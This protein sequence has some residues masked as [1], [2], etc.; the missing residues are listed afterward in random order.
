MILEELV[1]KTISA[2]EFK[3]RCL[4]LMDEVNSTAKR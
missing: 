4:T 3:A 1:M 2:A